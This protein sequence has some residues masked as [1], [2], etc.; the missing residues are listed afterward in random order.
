MTANDMNVRSESIAVIN[1]P[2]E[3]IQRRKAELAAIREQARERFESGATGVQVAA[4]VSD[5]M[6][7]YIV[8]LFESELAELPAGDREKLRE[9]SALVA[10]GGTGRGELA[11]YSDLDL[12]F[13]YSSKVQGLYQSFSSQIVR[14]YWDGGIELGHS[15]RTIGETLSLAKTE[16]QI[17]TALVE[18][19]LLWGSEDLFEQL[20]NRFYRKVVRKRLRAF[21]QDCIAARGEERGQFGTTVHQLE[22]DVKR[23]AGGLRDVHL[24]R[25]IGYAHYQTNDINSLRLKGVLSKED[26]RHLVSAYEFLMRIRIELHLA[27]NKPQ[28]I[29]TRD[30]QLRIAEKWGITAVGGQRPVER[31]MQMYFRHCRRIALIVDRFLVYHQPRKLST[32]IWNAAIAH[33]AEG[34]YLVSDR[35]MDVL[36]RFRKEVLGSLEEILRLYHCGMLNGLAPVPELVDALKPA[37]ARLPDQISPESADLFLTILG[38]S[39]HLGTTLRSLYDV[40]VLERLIP[41]MAHARCLLQFNQY[42]SY[43]VDEHTLR[44]VEAATDFEHSPGA[45][46]NAYRAVQRKEIL[47]LALLLHD[48]GKGFEEDHSEVGK[49]IAERI[50]QRLNLPE[51]RG[52]ILSF[53]VHKHLMMAH[54]AFRRDISDPEILM[55]FSHSV[56]S[57]NTLRMLFVLTAADITA[58]GPGVW[59]Y[60]KAELLSELYDSTMHVLSGRRLQH[61]EEKRLEGIKEY[62]RTS[63]VPLKSQHGDFSVADWINRQLDAFPPHYINEYSPEQIA[64]DLDTIQRLEPGEFFLDGEADPET[65]TVTYRLITHE[66]SAAGCFH[67]TVGVLTAKR[68][69]ILSADISTSLDGYV[70]DRYRVIDRDYEGPI[71]ESRIEDI[72]QSIKS[73]LKGETEVKPLFRRNTRFQR[74]EPAD[75]SQLPVRVVVDNNTSPRCTIIDVFAHDRPG[76]LYTATRTIYKLG[77]SVM[78]A[79]ISTHLDQVV[80]VFYV[81][82]AGGEKIHDGDRI[83]HIRDHL[84]QTIQD[85]ERDGYLQFK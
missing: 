6:E 5:A 25:W 43:T 65:G 17:A 47:H 14:A 27:A 56:G 31:F 33:R 62:L 49:L 35:G 67:R 45:L 61:R 1:S 21:T 50:A 11:P 4:T 75:F 8:R 59:T 36:P 76:L 79:K 78:L 26:A 28:D 83:R 41:D 24:L 9:H 44:A 69:E 72:S 48:L 85:F 64:S 60:W 15:V 55:P 18:A 54:L 82:D 68:L 66:N 30:E 46:G 7:A 70:V 10:V 40:G 51:H 84:C 74:E 20:Q 81:T 13:L 53:L 77:L 32:R 52:Q 80:D 29:L 3:I 23:C 16:P 58:V 73:A 19:R 39:A 63:I 38:R 42:H 37:V 34:K 12:L 71:P 22:P 2:L 57:P